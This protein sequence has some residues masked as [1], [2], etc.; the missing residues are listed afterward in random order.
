MS[1][2]AA[3]KPFFQ[4]ESDGAPRLPIDIDPATVNVPPYL[5]DTPALRGD[6]A[7][8]RS[9]LERF[10]RDA[11]SLIELL[12]GRG[13]L[14]DTL[15]IMTGAG[16]WSFP[17]GKETLY[18]A[19]THVPLVAMYKRTVPGGRTSKT[20]ISSE[21][22]RATFL[23]VAG[24]TEPTMRSLMPLMVSIGDHA[25]P[26]LLMRREQPMDAYSSRAIRT[27]RYLYIRNV[28]PNRWPAG[29]P[30]RQAVTPQLNNLAADP[31]MRALVTRLDRQLM[32]E[33]KRNEDPRHLSLRVLT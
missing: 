33:L 24:K 28:F 20:S 22:L 18:D 29:A 9:A 19:G 26:F 25:R 3:G 10:D 31:T 2:R 12:A 1:D 6:I 15:V 27:P 4:F 21:D 17:R 32:V 7:A 13:E 23:D 8:Y 16:G 14:A 30:A 11:G 5:P